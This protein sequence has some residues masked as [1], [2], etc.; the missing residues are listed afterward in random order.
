MVALKAELSAVIPGVPGISFNTWDVSV[1]GGADALPGTG[2]ALGTF[3]HYSPTDPLHKHGPN[4]VA[5]HHIRDILYKRVYGTGAAGVAPFH[6]YG[7]MDM[8]QIKIK[9]FGAIL[10]ST[11]IT[12][13]DVAMLVAA[14]ATLAVKL[15]PGAVA[16]APADNDFSSFNPA[17]ATVAATG[18]VTGVSPGTTV[19]RIVNK[20][21]GYMTEAGV[22]VTGALGL[23]SEGEGGQQMSADVP[24][25]SNKPSPEVS[26]EIAPRMAPVTEEDPVPV[27]DINGIGPVTASKL[28]SKGVTTARE[29]AELTQEEIDTFD[30]ELG[31][32]GKL[33]DWVDEAK[34]LVD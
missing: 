27:T 10:N 32:G 15:Q 13:A 11:G 31:F 18:V 17:I 22:T 21:T 23:L 12:A 9:R 33:Q 7:F 30:E 8:S 19:I 16:S 2:T 24:E 14:T 1:A 6:P 20:Y 34:T 25:D 3:E 26:P 28:E 29:L 5:F 4:H